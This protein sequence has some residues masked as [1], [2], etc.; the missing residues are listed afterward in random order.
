VPAESEER[1]RELLSELTYLGA[2]AEA[3]AAAETVVEADSEP[4]AEPAAPAVIPRRPIVAAGLAFRMPGG[5]HFH[6][7]RP[8]T[9]LLI[10][11]VL[12][13]GW[14]GSLTLIDGKAKFG[15]ELLFGTLLALVF[16]DAIG[17]ARAARDENRGIH[18]SRARQFARGFVLLAS[19]AAVGTGFAAV[20]ATPRWL[21]ARALAQ[22][23]VNCSTT[24]LMV[25]NGD[26]EGRL[27]TVSGLIIRTDTSSAAPG[28]AYRL[29]PDTSAQLELGAGV[30]GTID[31]SLPDEFRGQCVARGCEL[32]YVL[33]ASRPGDVRVSLLTGEGTCVP[34]WDRPGETWPG[35][36]EPAAEA[37]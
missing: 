7:R 6:A 18:T 11:T 24:A 35:R 20:G 29:G 10:G 16:A 2:N 12:F 31:L 19:A 15:G 3:E 23:D 22:F 36:I 25:R 1:A 32:Q 33:R 26:G 27:L 14:L 34:F 17:G 30:N 8:W 9:G 28:P 21:Q 5:G 4:D 37:E 13:C